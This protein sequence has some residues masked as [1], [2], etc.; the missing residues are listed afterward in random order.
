MIWPFK[1]RAE[2]RESSYTDTLMANHRR[3]SR[4]WRSF[5][6]R[7]RRSGGV[8]GHHRAV[9]CGRDRER[10]GSPGRQCHPA[11]PV[12]DRPGFDPLW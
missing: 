11:G 8:G 4:R 7:N 12:N 6:P 1:Q 9:F 10:A 5:S 2:V 3:A